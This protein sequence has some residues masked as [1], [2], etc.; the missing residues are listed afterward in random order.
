M[1]ADLLLQVLQLPEQI[2]Q[3]SAHLPILI[4]SASAFP[5]DLDAGRAAGAD[6]YVAKPF[7]NAELL[8]RATTLLRRCQ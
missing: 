2:R 1:P 4:V 3:V 7:A 8:A 6:N 5:S